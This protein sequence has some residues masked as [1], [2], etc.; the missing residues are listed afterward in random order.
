MDSPNYAVMW[1]HLF[2]DLRQPPAL[3]VEIKALAMDNKKAP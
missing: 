1:S 2:L 3:L